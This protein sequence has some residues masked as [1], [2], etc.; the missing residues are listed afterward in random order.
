MGQN[1]VLGETTF[2]D[3]FATKKS[4]DTIFVISTGGIFQVELL[5][6]YTSP[7]AWVPL[8]IELLPR[9]D[10]PYIYNFIY[11]FVYGCDG[12]SLLHRLFSSCGKQGLLSSC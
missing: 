4:C 10:C 11:L 8:I 5:G 12:S 3:I 6:G 9:P 2:L 1:S 7:P